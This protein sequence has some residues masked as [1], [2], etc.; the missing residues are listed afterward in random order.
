VSKLSQGDVVIL[1]Y[2]GNQYSFLINGVYGFSVICNLVNVDHRT[3][4]LKLGMF[5][6]GSC[7]SLPLNLLMT[8]KKLHRT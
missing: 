1:D 5:K 2:F 4:P 8:T 7:G 6:D 3:L